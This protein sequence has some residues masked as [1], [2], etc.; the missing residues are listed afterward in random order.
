MLNLEIER[1]VREIRTCDGFQVQSRLQVVEDGLACA[2]PAALG[3]Q[4]LIIEK[5]GRQIP[6]E[7]IGFKR[8]L[9]QLAPYECA[10]ELRSGQLVLRLPERRS[11]PVGNGILGRIFD[12][13]G[14]PIDGKGPVRPSERR[15]VRNTPPSP[16]QRERIS[17]PFITGQKAIDGLLLCGRGQRLGIFAGSGVGKSTLMG[18]I[19]KSAEADMN[20][21][22]LVGERGCELRPFVEDCL[23]QEGIAKSAV[24]ISSSDQ[25][26]MMR[27]RA[28]ETAIAMADSFRSRGANVLFFLD[29]LTRLAMAQRELGLSLGEPPSARGYTPSV[30]QILANTVEQLGNSATGSITGF[31]TVLVEGD[32]LSEPVA[33]SAR[34]LLDGHIVLDR[35]IAESGRF[36]AIN[37]SNSVSRAFLNVSDPAQQAAARKIRNIMATYADVQD[38]IRIGAYTK[39]TSP[40][41]DKVVELMP[42]VNT[43]LQQGLRERRTLQETCAAMQRL[44]M[45]WPY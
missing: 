28:V 26:P 12:G 23:G 3:D 9:S 2:L 20:V 30:F 39:G 21:I 18:E 11:V 7:V 33:D 42:A 25:L 38:L 14:R 31:L 24:V 16:L 13:L 1:L 40:Q 45:A 10:D 34:S 43:F 44:A 36:P 41:I 6:A 29:S 5:G 8:G 15:V 27:I 17:K 32:D 4:C 22:C 19:A 37:I 35:K